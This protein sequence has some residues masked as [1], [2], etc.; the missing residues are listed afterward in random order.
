MSLN[1][2]LSN[3]H[4][5]YSPLNL[6]KRKNRHAI[7]QLKVNKVVFNSKTILAVGAHPDDIELGAGGTVYKAVKSGSKVIALYMTKGGKN[8]D[9]RMRMAESTQAMNILGVTRNLL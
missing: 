5:R 3:K 1:T 9:S 7:Q 4:N 6:S 8:T 2:C